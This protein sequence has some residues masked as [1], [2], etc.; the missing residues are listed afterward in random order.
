MAVI[1]KQNSQMEFPLQIKRQ[2]PAPIEAN[3]VWY[4]LEALKEYAKSGATAYAGQTVKFI[5]EDNN[6]KITIYTIQADG[7]LTAGGDAIH[8]HVPT[9]IQETDD[10][11]FVSKAEKTKWD[12]KYT[13]QETDDKFKAA[14]SGLAFKGTFDTLAD[15]P[16]AD[17]AKDGWF[18]IV[19]NE[20]TAQG[21]NVLVIFESTDKAWKQLGDLLVPGVATEELDG[22]M[23]KEMVKALN[24]AGIDIAGLKDG[25]LLPKASATQIGAVKIGAN[26]QVSEDGTISTHAPYEHPENHPATM[27]VE[28]EAHRFVSD[29][30]KAVYTDKYTKTETDTK[31]S[32]SEEKITTAYQAADKVIND[33]VN[34]IEEAY[35]SADTKLQENI[36]A[37][38]TELD[39]QIKAVDSKFVAATD[40]EIDSLFDN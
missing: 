20:P 2:Y 32:E 5:D 3:E 29:A 8:T 22:L 18:A 14:I 38:K 1:N 17:E 6:N 31:I 39:A 35:K 9:D 7:T 19:V 30:D 21:K 4:D 12:D 36:N 28:D 13:K 24:K 11:Q 33:K 25:S 40:E 10:K 26:I 34:E 37:A 15:L 23:G 27:I 16:S